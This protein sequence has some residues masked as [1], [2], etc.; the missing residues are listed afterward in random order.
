MSGFQWDR[1]FSKIFSVNIQKFD[2]QHTSNICLLSMLEE[3]VQEHQSK[4]TILDI[5]DK[6]VSNTNEHFSSEEKYMM[7][8]EYPDYD[9]H[10]IIHQDF[11]R[12]T[13]ELV[14][15]YRENRVMLSDAVLGDLK[16][17][18]TEH[19]LSTDKKYSEYLNEKGLN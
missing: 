5:L 10:R 18:W 3:A 15:E 9:N 12:K 1:I 17:W 6:I 13:K 14:T 8:Y 4:N 16:D 19:I 11:S 2:H 7:D